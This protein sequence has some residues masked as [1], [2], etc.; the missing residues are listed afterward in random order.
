[1]SSF[2]LVH[3]TH[4][5][6]PQLFRLF[7]NLLFREQSYCLIELYAN[8]SKDMK[9]YQTYVTVEQIITLQESCIF[10]KCEVL[11]ANSR[12]V[13]TQQGVF[14]VCCFLLSR[15][16]EAKANVAL[17]Q[18]IYCSLIILITV[19]ISVAEPNLFQYGSGTGQ[20]SSA[21]GSATLV[22]LSRLFAF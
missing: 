5:I 13:G 14:T 7:C 17:K 20:K 4:F 12:T 19:K 10:Q 8:T 11:N 2:L 16:V 22:H 6:S 15:S 21:P 1:M 9:T 3:L 18:N